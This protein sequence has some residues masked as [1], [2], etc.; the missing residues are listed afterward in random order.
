DVR[1]APG[2][3]LRCV[4]IDPPACSVGSVAGSVGVTCRRAPLPSVGVASA[5]MDFDLPPEDDP[6]R[7]AVRGW[8]SE[9][10]APSGRQLAE[11]GYVAPHWPEPHGLAADP[12]H[13]L[14]ID[15]ELRRAGVQR[16][17]NQIGIGWAGPTIL[18][19]GTDE[20]K[21]RYLLPLLAGE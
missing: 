8:R 5:R 1:P 11:A 2:G 10:P 19:A 6:R 4:W 3:A 14:V 21:E 17:S 12:V 16:P 9:N 13:Q 18:H 20:Q 15:D 7:L